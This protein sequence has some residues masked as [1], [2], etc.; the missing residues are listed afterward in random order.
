[1]ISSKW[2]LSVALAIT[3]LV[4]A[5]GEPEAVKSE[6]EKN[7]ISYCLSCHGTGAVGGI[8]PNI[9][10]SAAAGIANYSEADMLKLVRTGVDTESMMTCAT[11]TRFSA[12]A[13]SDAKVQTIYD[14]LKTLKNDKVNRGESCP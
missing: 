13:L 14:Y 5:C 7:Y 4:L 3:A 12:S 8:G 2:V 1:M 6:G 9:T 10:F 11:M